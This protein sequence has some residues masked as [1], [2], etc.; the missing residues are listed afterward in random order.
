MGLVGEVVLV[1]VGYNERTGFL[2][3]LQNEM[4]VGGG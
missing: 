2:M 1:C 3:V 4:S